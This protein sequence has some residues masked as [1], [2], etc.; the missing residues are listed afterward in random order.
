MSCSSGA[1][2]HSSCTRFGHVHNRRCVGGGQGLP[3]PMRRASARCPGSS[4]GRTAPHS[5]PPLALQADAPSRSQRD[6][7]LALSMTPGGRPRADPSAHGGAVTR[8]GAVI[9]AAALSRAAALSSLRR[10]C[11]ARRRC[12]SQRQ[13]CHS[14]R[15]TAVILS[16]AK[17]LF[18]CRTLLV[19][20]RMHSHPL[21]G[22]GFALTKRCFACAQHDTARAAAR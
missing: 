5:E 17:N 11:H 21:K 16:E 22:S 8:A 20:G 9:P 19:H 10:P 13:R 1:A 7:S 3:C 14:E 12:H 2:T 6:A 18:V 4:A 15:A